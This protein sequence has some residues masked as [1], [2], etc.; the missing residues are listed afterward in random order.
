MPGGATAFGRVSNVVVDNYQ[1]V[2][3][4]AVGPRVAPSA[5][6]FADN[7]IISRRLP[8]LAEQ[9]SILIV[10]GVTARV[11]GNTVTGCVCDI[12]GCGADPITEFQAIGV[13]AAPIGAGTTISGNHLSGNSVAPATGL[14]GGLPVGGSVLGG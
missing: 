8:V 7:V 1:D 12:P 9:V 2:A 10:G 5:V 4:Q 3:L 11:T 6:T 14:L 13:F